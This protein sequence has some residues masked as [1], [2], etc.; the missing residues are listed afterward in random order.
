MKTNSDIPNQPRSDCGSDV[1]RRI[2]HRQVLA[3]G[4]QSIES[5]AMSFGVTTQTIRRD[6]NV[7]CENGLCRRL[8]GGVDVLLG[9]ENL[10]YAA[11]RTMHLEAKRLIARCVAARIPQGASLFFG[12]GT[13][14]E[15]CALALSRH[16]G[17]RVMTN[18]LNV[19]MALRHSSHCELTIAGGRMRNSDGDVIA[20]E[21]HDFFTR[22]EVDVGI[23]GA[24]GVTADGGLLDFNH[25]EIRMRTA[26]VEHCRKSFLVLDASKFGRGATVRG[27]HITDA[28]IVFTDRPVP[29]S[30]AH[31]LQCAGVELVVANPVTPPL[32][33]ESTLSSLRS[34]HP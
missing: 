16:E 6:V 12:I 13:T 10:A 11:R 18:N 34:T 29:E 15:Q 7:L 2:I 32:S 23:C 22:F 17:L 1:R 31:M 5:L 25:D 21:A 26:L 3:E 28:S 24:G 14:P 20:G 19:A 8:H 30:I 9:D 4:Y 33:A 27:G